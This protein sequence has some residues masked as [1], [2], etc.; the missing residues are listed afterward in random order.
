MVL[1]AAMEGGLQPCHRNSVT[2]EGFKL[3]VLF[4]TIDDIMFPKQMCHVL[5][6]VQVHTAPS[7]AAA[8]AAALNH[9]Q[10]APMMRSAALVATAAAAASVCGGVLLAAAPVPGGGNVMGQFDDVWFT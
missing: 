10:S 7:G 9:H 5:C 3:R 8:A 4:Q 2:A 1:R 6:C